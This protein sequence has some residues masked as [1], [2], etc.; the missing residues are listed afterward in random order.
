[1]TIARTY[2]TPRIFRV[3][4]PRRRDLVPEWS[5]NGHGEQR[6]MAWIPTKTLGRTHSGDST[7]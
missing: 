5:A 7:W 1:M 3:F 4:V 2:R 6:I